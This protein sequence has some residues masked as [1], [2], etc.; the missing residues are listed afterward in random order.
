M[1]QEAHANYVSFPH[2]E[3]YIS[4]TTEIIA[5]AR[6]GRMFILVDDERRENEGDLIIPA[7]FATAEAINFMARHARGLICLAM[8]PHR[9][10]QLGLPPMAVRNGSVYETAFTV[11]IE[12]RTGVTT[13]ISAADRAH[14]IAI[15]INPETGWNDISI[16]GHVF[17]LCAREGG[18]LMR[19]GHTEAAVDVSRMAGLNPSGVICEIMNEDGTMA[20]LPDLVAFAQLHNLKLGTIADLI[21]YRRK[22][23]KLVEHVA[24]TGL[25]HPAF[26]EWRLL[27][28]RDKVE[29]GEHIVLAKGDLS[30]SDPVLVRL[31]A[32]DFITDALG[33]ID[34]VLQAAMHRI[35]QESRGVIVLINDPRPNAISERLSTVSPHRRPDPRMRD[36]GV[37]AQIL[38]DLGVRDMILL[39]DRAQ[40]LVGLEG[41]GLNVIDPDREARV[42]VPL[43]LKPSEMEPASSAVTAVSE[44]E[45]ELEKRDG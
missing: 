32:V 37:G 18:T 17:P 19:A 33:G 16:P 11:S 26:G 45:S 24:E 34:G 5:E 41:Y 25:H 20:R 7:Q 43:R 31:H 21:A 13:G 1:T 14:T 15:A 40:T 28:Y 29:N 6:K 44:G 38:I 12:A 22:T 42:S 8:T 35:T 30:D 36:Y 9:V 10:E 23:E 4:S 2:L 39:S 27:V 3:G